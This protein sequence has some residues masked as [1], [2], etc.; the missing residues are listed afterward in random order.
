MKRTKSYYIILALLICSATLMGQDTFQKVS[1]DRSYSFDSKTKTSEVE[2][3]IT[4][5]FNF[6]SIS[7]RSEISEGKI[8]IEIYNPKGKS[9]GNY[10]LGDCSES[11][12][13]SEIRGRMSKSFPEPINGKW[14]IKIAAKN[15]KGRV[16]L[17]TNKNLMTHEKML[18]VLTK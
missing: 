9:V 15:C 18:D 3:E 1:L 14:K 5:E 12:N 10:E 7:A 8:T 16:W 2:V 6:L 11:E 4:S 17:S 13:I